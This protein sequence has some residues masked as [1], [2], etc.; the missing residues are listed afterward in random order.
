MSSAGGASPDPMSMSSRRAPIQRLD[1][2]SLEGAA[3]AAVLIGML[4]LIAA[5]VAFAF[6]VSSFAPV[7]AAIPILSIAVIGEAIAARWAARQDAG[8]LAG[9]LAAFAGFWLSYAVLILGLAYDWFGVTPGNTIGALALFLI[10]WLAVMLVMVVVNLEMPWTY[11]LLLA[12]F[13]AALALL[14]VGTLTNTR[15]WFTGA[16]ALMFSLAAVAIYITLATHGP[17]R[18][19]QVMPIGSGILARG[20]DA[21]VSPT[22]SQDSVQR[23]Y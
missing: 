23:N 1:G 17:S 6:A 4:A 8:A 13:A 11:I 9:I 14:L 15:G 19:R 2:H 21:K 7:G 20:S 3:T 18:L 10:S 16:G 22:S 12:L 5:S